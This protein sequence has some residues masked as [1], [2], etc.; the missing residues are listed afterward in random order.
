M[1]LQL[2]IGYT[3]IIQHS[4]DGEKKLGDTREDGLRILV[5]HIRGKFF[6][7]V[8]RFTMTRILKIRVVVKFYTEIRAEHGMDCVQ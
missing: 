1:R 6:F 8:Y 7:V 5:F 3:V 2:E 4:M